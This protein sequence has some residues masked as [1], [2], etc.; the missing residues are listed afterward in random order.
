MIRLDRTDWPER[1]AR[2]EQ[3]FETYRAITLRRRLRRTIESRRQA[4]VH[5]RLARFEMPPE[6]I[7]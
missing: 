4:E 1:R 7:H 6:R 2:I 5:Q 3:M